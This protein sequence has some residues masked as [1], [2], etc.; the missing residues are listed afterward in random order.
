MVSFLFFDSLRLRCLKR[1]RLIPY[2]A[3]HDVHIGLTRQGS[4]SRV[5]HH[6]GNPARRSRRN[7]EHAGFQR[8]FST[9]VSRNSSLLTRHYPCS[10]CVRQ[11]LCMIVLVVIPDN[12]KPIRSGYLLSMQDVGPNPELPN[13]AHLKARG[14][15]N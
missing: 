4:I 8:I 13:V 14:P 15:D 1:H 5:S 6:D 7:S 9:V 3:F 12:K 11:R 10:T 2:P